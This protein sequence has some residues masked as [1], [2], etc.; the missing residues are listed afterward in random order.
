M[1]LG[2]P[3]KKYI[4]TWMVVWFWYEWRPNEVWNE[5]AGW[6]GFYNGENLE[7]IR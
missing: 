1:N 3:H 6:G 7:L 2:L 4:D 5:L